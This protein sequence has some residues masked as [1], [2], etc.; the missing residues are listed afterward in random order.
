ME[1]TLETTAPAALEPLLFVSED[2]TT[3]LN[4]LITK[5]HES[6]M[7]L[8]DVLPWA[9]GIDRSI[10]PKRHDHSMVYGTPYWDRLTEEQRIE[11]LW[12]EVAQTAS[13]F[14]WLEEGLSPLF[15]GLLHRNRTQMPEA[16][17]EYMLLF[18]KEELVHTQ[19]FRRWLKLANLSVYERPDF[20]QFIDE[21]VEMHPV[22]GVLCTYLTEGIAEETAIRQEGPGIEPL[23]RQMFFE[24]HREELRHLAFGR[25]VCESFF[26]TVGP[27]T[28]AQIGM[29]VRGFMGTIVPLYTYNPEITRYLSFDLGIDPND[30]ETIDRI[31]RSANN[32][33]LNHERFG[34]MLEWV[35][36]LGLASPE[37]QWL[38]PME[39]M[40]SL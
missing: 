10:A 2:R 11:L 37:Y 32:E 26:A 33:R 3:Q 15:I 39:P 19:M 27:Q 30:T 12:V 4:N 7:D 24:H 23:T 13:A 9:N 35:K 8:N 14:I 34:P 28:K 38:D 16:I 29:L 18:C 6:H 36:K 40:P 21:L 25:W 5:S 22:A 1:Q 31:R 17:Y 20:M